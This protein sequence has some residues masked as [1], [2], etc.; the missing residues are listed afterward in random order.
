MPIRWRGAFTRAEPTKRPLA[1]ESMIGRV[2]K[3]FVASRGAF[4]ARMVDFASTVAYPFGLMSPLRRNEFLRVLAFFALLLFIS[5]LLAESVVE[6]CEMRCAFETSQSS[7]DHDKAP[8]QCICAAHIGAVIV[9]DFA[10][11]LGT[12][13]NPT[14]FLPG[15]DEGRP[16]RLA[17]TIDHPPQLS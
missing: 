8:C 17:A 11:P 15:K 14:S 4:D 7:P 3:T 6:V 16:P 13:V 10:M 12:D 1:A 2:R 5:D 9:T